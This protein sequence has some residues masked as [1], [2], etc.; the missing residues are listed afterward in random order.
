MESKNVLRSV[1]LWLGFITSG[2][3]PI[4]LHVVCDCARGSNDTR[5]FCLS[6][7]PMNQYSGF[8][9]RGGIPIIWIFIS[10][11]LRGYRYSVQ[12]RRPLSTSRI[13]S[14]D[15]LLWKDIGSSF[16][17]RMASHIEH[18]RRGTVRSHH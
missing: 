3:I 10:P 7:T 8:V 11:R 15:D 16:L 4:H 9:T 5:P 17:V 6:L 13:L 2:G 12:M 18:A 14:M 1:Y